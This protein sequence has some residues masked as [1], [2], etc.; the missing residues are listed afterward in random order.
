MQLNLT[1]KHIGLTL[2]AV[3]A[4]GIPLAAVDSGCSWQTKDPTTGLWRE[5][6]AQ[7]MTGFANDTGAIVR[8]GISGTPL[9]PVLPWADM[10]IR[11]LVLFAAWRIVPSG[12]AEDKKKT[13]TPVLSANNT[14]H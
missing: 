2:L 14:I 10:V 11:L 1:K 13:A 8:T 4:L 3:A 9:A 7:E 12:A 6:T 5:S